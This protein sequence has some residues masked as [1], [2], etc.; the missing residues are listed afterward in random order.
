[1]DWTNTL[2]G[3]NFPLPPLTPIHLS[4]VDAE[5]ALALGASGMVV[6][7][8]LGYEEAIEAHCLKIAVQLALAGRELGLPL[9]AEVRPSGPQV[10]RPDKAIELGAS[11]AQEGGADIIIVPNPGPGSLKTIAGMLTVP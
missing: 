7:L 2:R 11:F 10:A 8:L 1:M 3:P 4:V 6:N 9:I 5:D